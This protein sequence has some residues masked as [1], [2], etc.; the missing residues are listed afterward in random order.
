MYTIGYVSHSFSLVNFKLYIAQ[1]FAFSL[2]CAKK[3]TNDQIRLTQRDAS[4]QNK[5][6]FNDRGSK[7]IRNTH[8]QKRQKKYLY[9]NI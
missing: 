9:Q 1:P 4:Y 8:T 6:T 5:K 3:V 7:T 2:F